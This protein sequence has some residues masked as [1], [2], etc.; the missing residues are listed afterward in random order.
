MIEKR[1]IT[2]I[3][4]ANRIAIL[5]HVSVDGDGLGSSLA[6]ALALKTI[7]KLATVYIEEEIPSNYS[8]C[9][10]ENLFKF[11]KKILISMN[12]YWHWTQEI[13]KDWAKE[14]RFLRMPKEV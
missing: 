7:N 11:I 10:E 14:S 12:W 5:P 13:W 6:L 3:N 9:P 1:I 8:F 4:E 2:L